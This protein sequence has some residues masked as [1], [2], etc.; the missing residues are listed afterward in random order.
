MNQSLGV[1]NS[2]AGMNSIC[3][4]VMSL[5]LISK[6]L[7]VASPLPAPFS[8]FRFPFVSPSFKLLISYKIA[9]LFSVHR[10]LLSSATVCSNVMALS[11]ILLS[12]LNHGLCRPLQATCVC[13][14][15]RT[16]AWAPPWFWHGC[17]TLASRGRTRRRCA[18]SH[19]RAPPCAGTHAAEGEGRRAIDRV[20]WYFEICALK[21]FII[22][23]SLTMY[24][25]S[26]TSLHTFHGNILYLANGMKP[27]C[28]VG[29][30]S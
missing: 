25:F 4:S 3:I 2:W 28:P 23:I 13:I 12:P 8:P 6:D 10:F 27:Y 19:L 22:V 30:H 21:W 29:C 18:T 16:R 11:T 17:P 15:R 14:R 26:V 7:T 1:S 5:S 24:L 20:V 9:C